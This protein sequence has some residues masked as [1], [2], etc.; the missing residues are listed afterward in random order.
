VTLCTQLTT[1]KVASLADESTYGLL[2]QA[3]SLLTEVKDLCL[4]NKALR[5]TWTGKTTHLTLV[6]KLFLENQPSESFAYRYSAD[7]ARSISFRTIG[8]DPGEDRRSPTRCK[9]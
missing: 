2:Y 4:T 1:F 7:A 6:L 3:L 8:D 9:R 5:A